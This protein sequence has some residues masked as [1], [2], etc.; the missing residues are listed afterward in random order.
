M[1]ANSA[2][3]EGSYLVISPFPPGSMN[4]YDVVL[5]IQALTK[6]ILPTTGCSQILCTFSLENLY[7]LN[8]SKTEVF[9]ESEPHV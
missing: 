8:G 6:L 9:V 7:K 5:V 1:F 2:C 3:G 4:V